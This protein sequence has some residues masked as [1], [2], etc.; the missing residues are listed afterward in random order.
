[1]SSF[2]STWSTDSAPLV[3]VVIPSF[4]HE[5][6][7]YQCLKSISDQTYENIEL[8]I[9]DDCSTDGSFNFVQNLLKTPFSRRFARVDI[10]RNEENQGAHHTINTGISRSKGKLITVIN[11]DDEFHPQR[12]TKII[13]EMRS[14]D[15]DLG[16]SL[17]D[18]IND[19]EPGFTE[20][21]LPFI[22]FTVRQ[23][24][25]VQF[26]VTLG[27]GLLRKNLAV[28]TG[29]LV[30]SRDLYSRIGGFLS[31][32]Y[33][34]DWDF[35]LQ[36]L[37]YCEPAVV[38]LPLYHY[39]LHPQNSFKGLAH[40]AQVETEVVLRRFFRLVVEREPVNPLCPSP[41]TWPGYFERFVR[42]RGF[43]RYLDREAGR[44]LPSW[45]TYEHAS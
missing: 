19:N 22:Q 43:A 26:D 21:L 18:I 3:S 11:S 29:N 28:S 9:V 24:L 44:G 38:S 33:C 45:R 10:T 7:L 41:W 42:Q 1:M 32:K 17:V 4:N 15:T 6:Y 12:L 16:F 13:D 8:V 27:F 36:S 40:M 23:L 35:V 39:R 30:F 2:S 31:L 34:H 20:D 5:K 25:D 14:A 37:Y